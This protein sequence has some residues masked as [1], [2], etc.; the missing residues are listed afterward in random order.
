MANGIY[1]PDLNDPDCSNALS[2]SIVE[3]LTIFSKV[4]ESILNSKMEF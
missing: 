2:S 3:E 4:V 1:N